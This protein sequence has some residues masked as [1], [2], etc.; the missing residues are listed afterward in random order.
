MISL[1]IINLLLALR[2]LN[3]NYIPGETDEHKK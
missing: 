1:R 3:M 2:R